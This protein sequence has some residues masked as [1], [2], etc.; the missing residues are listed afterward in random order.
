MCGAFSGRATSTAA[1]GVV[2]DSFISYSDGRRHRWSHN[3]FC[4]NRHDIFQNSTAEQRQFNETPSQRHVS[5]GKR[6]DPAV[7]AVMWTRRQRC[8]CR[9]HAKSQPNQQRAPP[10]NGRAGQNAR[11]RRGRT[12]PATRGECACPAWD[13]AEC[14]HTSH[15]GQRA[16]L[17]RRRAQQQ[18]HLARK[19]GAARSRV[20]RTHKTAAPPRTNG[21]SARNTS[22]APYKAR[23]VREPRAP[24]HPTRKRS[25]RSNGAPRNGKIFAPCVIRG[26]RA[27]KSAPSWQDLRAVYPPTAI[28]GAFRIHGAH[29]LPK[30]ARFGC[31]A[32]ESCH[33]APPFSS[34]AP[35]GIHGV[36][37]LPRIAAWERTAAESCR[38]K[39]SENAPRENI[40]T[41]SQAKSASG[42]N[43]ATIGRL[44]AHRGEILPLPVARERISRAFCHRRVPGNAPWHNL[45]VAGSPKMHRGN[46]L[47]R[48]PPS[49]M[50]LDDIL[51]RRPS[52]ARACCEIAVVSRSRKTPPERSVG[53]FN[54][55]C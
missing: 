29:I 4:V 54:T 38:G 20:W 42:H 28:C 45:A 9:P 50:L 55:A 22:T 15:G 41:A 21:N 35:F 27:A 43:H 34:E 32:R 40:A 52:T 24:P 1:V 33:E 13:D 11:G 30:P 19:R 36:K 48:Q 37:K 17:T 23:A 12:Y 5:C 25:K 8:E 39:T 10:R 7:S 49:R 51:P 16:R 3:P 46:T 18:E 14:T 53:Q 31:M 44:G 6:H 2:H 26:V 47:P